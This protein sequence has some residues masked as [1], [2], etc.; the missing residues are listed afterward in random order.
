M[1]IKIGGDV[2]ISDAEK[3]IFDGSVNPGEFDEAGRTAL[4]ADFTAADNGTLIWYTPESQLQVYN[5]PNWENASSGSFSVNTPTL[6]EPKAN[7]T[8]DPNDVA[9]QA[10]PYSA[11]P[12]EQVVP[13]GTSRWQIATASDFADDSLVVNAVNNSPRFFDVST[14]QA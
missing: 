7:A 9:M 4:S 11:D 1:S 3:G 2:V 14:T 6:E 10:S 5:H 12:N 13:Y 8:V